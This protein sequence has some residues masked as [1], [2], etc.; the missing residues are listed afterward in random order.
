MMNSMYREAQQQVAAQDA[1][2]RRLVSE[3]TVAE[4]RAVMAQVLW[5]EQN[6]RSPIA[7]DYYPRPVM[8][9]PS[10]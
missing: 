9:P 5:D 6:R 1:F 3:L 2:E 7:T 10:Q 4:F 8:A